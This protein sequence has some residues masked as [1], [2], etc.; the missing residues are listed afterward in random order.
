MIHAG[1][2]GGVD[3]V[4]RDL[5]CPGLFLVDTQYAVY[6]WSGWWPEETKDEDN[7]KTGSAEARFNIDRRCALET[8]INYCKG[9]TFTLS[10]LERNP[11]VSHIF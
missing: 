8:A 7:V 6:V 10:S 5:C 11:A 2:E 1:T 4:F 3:V 9:T